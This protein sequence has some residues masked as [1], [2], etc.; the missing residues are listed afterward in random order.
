[1]SKKQEKI[2]MHMY[3]MD[4]AYL[5]VLIKMQNNIKSVQPGA[6]TSYKCRE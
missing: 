3:L 2:Y 6:N 4:F 1:M 5:H